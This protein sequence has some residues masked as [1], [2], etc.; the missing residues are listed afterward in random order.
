MRNVKSSSDFGENHFYSGIIFALRI[1]GCGFVCVHNLN[2]H[3][4]KY[5]HILLKKRNKVFGY[6]WYKAEINW[7]CKTMNYNCRVHWFRSFLWNLASIQWFH[8]KFLIPI[9]V[10]QW[11]YFSF[12]KVE[13]AILLFCI[14]FA[15]K[16]V[17]INGTF[18]VKNSKMSEACEQCGVIS[19]EQT[20]LFYWT[21]GPTLSNDQFCWT[22]SIQTFVFKKVARDAIW[23]PHLWHSLK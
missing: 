13:S 16:C 10:R 21:G 12:N 7:K 23:V 18:Q 4:E 6:L 15:H 22:T 17:Y 3:C 1:L 9:F 14:Y 8:M 5:I 11:V 19:I 2:V 20:D